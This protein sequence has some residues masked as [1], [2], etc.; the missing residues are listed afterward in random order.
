MSQDKIARIAKLLTQAQSAASIGND[1]EAQIFDEKAQNLMHEY[2]VEQA[3][4]HKIINK[5]EK[6]NVMTVKFIEVGKQ[7]TVGLKSRC[8]YL[9]VI[10]S[11]LFGIQCDIQH[12]GT[13]II[14]YGA[15][16]I[17]DDAKTLVE[18]LNRE[19][20]NGIKKAKQKTKELGERFSRISYD[21]GFFYT[22][23]ELAG[24][25]AQHRKN[26]MKKQ[27]G[28]DYKTAPVDVSRQHDTMYSHAVALRDMEVAVSDFYRKNSTAR[29]RINIGRSM[30]SSGSY[31]A[32]VNHAKNTNFSG[33][34]MLG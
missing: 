22:L 21:S 23:Q 32:G 20:V 11:K 12:N 16:G 8:N 14:A 4:I 1:K 24:N 15:Q 2:N 6:S 3:E 5:D 28:E 34:K 17:I 10:V 27:L 13:G 30:F 25:T 31:N 26:T 9:A 33:Q 7:G 19:N 18:H 29:G